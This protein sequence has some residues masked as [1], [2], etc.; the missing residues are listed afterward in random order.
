M[1]FF[2]LKRSHSQNGPCIAY[3]LQ[4]RELIG[5]LTVPALWAGDF[6]WIPVLLWSNHSAWESRVVL[7]ICR[8]QLQIFRLLNIVQI[9]SQTV[10]LSVFQRYNCVVARSSEIWCSV[11]FTMGYAFRSA[12]WALKKRQNISRV[13]KR[14]FFENSQTLSEKNANLHRQRNIST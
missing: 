2:R 4:H 9:A 5:R 12:F 11:S 8:L 1:V 14:L 6:R 13:S 10:F 7:H 3:S